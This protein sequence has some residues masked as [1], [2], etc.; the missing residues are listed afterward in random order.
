MTAGRPVH[1]DLDAWRDCAACGDPR[2]ACQNKRDEPMCGR[3][4][5]DFVRQRRQ[6]IAAGIQAGLRVCDIARA[7][8][9]GRGLVQLVRREIAA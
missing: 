1:V 5:A 8:G 7:N 4:R 9:C 2:S 6:A 3:C